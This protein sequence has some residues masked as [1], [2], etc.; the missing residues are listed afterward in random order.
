MSILKTQN[1]V[2]YC[3]HHFFS[4]LLTIDFHRFFSI[5]SMDNLDWKDKLGKAFGVDPA[6]VVPDDPADAPNPDAVPPG[7]Q[8]L[9]VLLDRHDRRGKKVTLI[10]GFVGSDDALKELAR[11]LKQQCGVGGSARG[12]EILIQGDFRQKILEI[13]KKAGYKARLIG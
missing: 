4:L 5:I 13:L 10:V 7:K 2:A 6:S 12:G 8:H 11:S 9:D 3:K 1:K